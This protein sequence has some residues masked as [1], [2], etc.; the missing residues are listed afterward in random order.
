[1]RR[2]AETVRRDLKVARKRWIEAA[3]DEKQRKAREASDFLAYRDHAGAY[4]DF[5][6]LRHTYITRLMR[7][8]V[9]THHAKDLARHASIR[10]TMRYTHTEADELSKALQQVP[11]LPTQPAASISAMA[12]AVG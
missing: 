11:S 10:T 2:T 12:S 3:P 1:M 6:S 7:S 5:H 9:K 8:G 4:C